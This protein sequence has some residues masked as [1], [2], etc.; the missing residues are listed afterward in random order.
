MT[1]LTSF[2]TSLITIAAIG[3]GW[4]ARLRGIAL[5]SGRSQLH[6]SNIIGLTF[7]GGEGAR[8]GCC[9]ITIDLNDINTARMGLIG[10][11]KR[12]TIIIFIIFQQIR[13]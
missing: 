1:S 6:V 11:R 10:I 2:T 13:H 9:Y 3:V 7:R 8:N 12:I 4:R 5:G